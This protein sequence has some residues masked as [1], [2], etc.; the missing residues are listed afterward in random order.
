MESIYGPPT[1]APPGPAPRRGRRPVLAALRVLGLVALG[2]AVLVAL[3]WLEGDGEIAVE[4]SLR[5]P[6][7]PMPVIDF[8]APAFRPLQTADIIPS[9]AIEPAAGQPGSAATARRPLQSADIIRR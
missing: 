2:T 3:V 6:P 9:S 5:A 4:R 7:T 8:G 1:G